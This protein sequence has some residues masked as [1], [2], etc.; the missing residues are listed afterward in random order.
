MAGR[1]VSVSGSS[2]I[3]V[4]QVRQRRGLA[5]DTGREWPI[6]RPL[7]HEAAGLIQIHVAGSGQRR[8]LATVD[9]DVAVLI[10]DVQ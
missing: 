2:P 10:G 4:R 9:H 1:S 5:G 3:P 7:G 8:T 6:Q